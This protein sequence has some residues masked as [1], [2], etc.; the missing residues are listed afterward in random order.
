MGTAVLLVAF[1]LQGCGALT[2]REHRV[3]GPSVWP[4][5]PRGTPHLPTLAVELSS[6]RIDFPLKSLRAPQ[7]S[8]LFS[9]VITDGLD[10]EADFTL[11]I[12]CD[13]IYDPRWYTIFYLLS[14]G[15]IPGNIARDVIVDATLTDRRKNKLGTWRKE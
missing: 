8:G 5:L 11:R 10:V 3:A 6:G 2:L 7:E 9:G 15:A 12:A 1:V 4:L 14:L 13:A